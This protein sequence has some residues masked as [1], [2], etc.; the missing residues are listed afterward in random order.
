VTYLD[1]FH[2]LNVA[3]NLAVLWVVIWTK[4]TQFGLWHQH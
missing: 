3:A 2:H 1:P 4:W